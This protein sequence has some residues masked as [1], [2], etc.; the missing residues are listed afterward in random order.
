[1]WRIQKTIILSVSFFT[2]SLANKK[3]GFPDCR[4]KKN[5]P[6]YEKS[7]IFHQ[8]T[9]H[10]GKIVVDPYDI[11]C[12]ENLITLSLEFLDKVILLKFYK[13]FI[14]FKLAH[15]ISKTILAHWHLNNLLKI[16][17]SI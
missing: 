12:L 15:F 11:H 17:K 4:D 9:F 1:M 13:D 10:L 16:S 5:P 7:L 14:I 8:P 6:I 2:S 3:K